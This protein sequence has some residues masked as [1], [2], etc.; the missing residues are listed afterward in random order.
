MFYIYGFLALL[1]IVGQIVFGHLDYR[2]QKKGVIVSR[3]KPMTVGIIVPVYNENEETIKHALDSMRWQKYDGEIKVFVIDDGSKNITEVERVYGYFE[4]MYPDNFFVL[5]KRNEG[6]RIAQFEGNEMMVRNG[7]KPEL[8]VTVDSDTVLTPTA[9]ASITESF[10]DQTVGAA[11]G[12]VLALNKEENLLTRLIN[13]RYWMAFNQERAAQSYFKVLMCCSGPFSAYRG[14]IFR[15]LMHKYTSQRFFGKLCTYGDDRHLT[16]LVL[17]EGWNVVYNKDAEAFTHVP[18][19]LR[20]YLKQ[21]LRWNKSF[22]REMLWTLKAVTK[23]NAYLIY[24]LAMQF[25]LPF[26]LIAAL[27]HTVY[28]A[29]FVDAKVILAYIAIMIGVSLLRVGYG[30]Y[31]TKDMGFYWFMLYGVF[32]VFVLI[33][34]RFVA[35]ATLNDGKWGTRG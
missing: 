20:T 16:N 6:K 21:Q 22:Y 31:R 32:H 1:H 2:R 9:I 28:V 12:N 11:T 29:A 33:P 24:D 15:G 5:R 35:L 18:T 27:M 7:F 8:V 17:E 3:E 19:T 23:H 25:L 10:G 30:L 13:Y 26:F 4:Q 14:N 34:V